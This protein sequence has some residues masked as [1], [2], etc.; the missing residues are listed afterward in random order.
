MQSRKVF[1]VLSTAIL[2]FA[3]FAISAS[4][5]GRG[6]PQTKPVAKPPQAQK[7]VLQRGGPVGTWNSMK[8]FNRTVPSPFGKAGDSCSG[9]CNCS[10]CVCNGSL[11]CCLDG[12]DFCWGVLDGSGSCNSI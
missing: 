9:A 12:C 7:I 6:T 5:A 4:A 11:G 1:Q 8:N 3:L 10:T 2:C